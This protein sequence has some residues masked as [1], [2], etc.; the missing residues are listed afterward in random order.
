M[1]FRRRLLLLF[2]FTVLLS[3]AAVTFII[4]TLA[5]RAFDRSSDER[6]AALVAQFRREFM[7][8]GDEVAGRLRAIASTTEAGRI[9]LAAAHPSPDYSPF[10]EA[11]QSVAAAQQLDF[12][13]FVDDR[14]A[15]ISSAQWPAKFGYNELLVTSE[16]RPASFLKQE[17]LPS[18]VALGLFSVESIPAGNRK[19][20]LVGGVRLDKTFLSAIDL[21]T[22]MRVM[23][24]QISGHSADVLSPA[25][26][27][28]SGEP[29][30]VFAQITPLIGRVQE[31]SRESSDLIR[32]A[33]GGEEA[34]N[35]FPLTGPN[36]QLLAILLVGSSRQAYAD[37]RR[38]IR[39]AA[40]LATGVGL[41]L[42]IGISSWAAARVTRPVEQLARAACEIS[43]GNW[44]VQVPSAS[45]DEIGQLA[46]SFNRM[47]RELL[48]QQQRLIQSER[49]AAW[50]ELA[51]RL[52]H[53]LKNPLFPLQ[54]TVENLLR[55]RAQT[56]EQF[57]EVF[58]ES[59]SALLS[60]ISNLKT[61]IARFSDF[62]RMPQPRFQPVRL[63]AIVQ[64]VARLHL[65]QMKSASIVC[66]VD[67][68]DSETI[69]ADPD[70]LHRAISNLVLNAV[71][72]MPQG[73]TIN[74][75][76]QLSGD[77]ARIEISDTGIGL[78]PEECSRLFT[79][80]YTSKA[81]GSGLGLAIVQ[82]I[83]SD[84]HGRITVSS[85]KGTGT[86]FIIELPANRDQLSAE[87]TLARS[88]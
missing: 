59:A 71:D 65:S 17:E 69:A 81:H 58:R 46:D 79:P 33:S 5:R 34:I 86:T 75:R 77:S 28:S 42:A 51:R 18:G 20:Y 31:N 32:W 48:D 8:K 53:E 52:A 41:L 16:L 67:L 35:A 87:G 88:L 54:L 50:R 84:H 57:D 19:V 55:A 38:Q 11:A 45:R 10:L 40:L 63:R 83:V 39:F 61:V 60:E 2:A 26:L 25:N 27:I 12:L 36:H 13:E 7:R 73:G 6:A 64:E 15:I 24:Y 78:T 1:S 29:A 9:A 4:S 23:L 43:A 70:L 76:T 21:P 80:Y 49:V 82:S 72:A 66:D 74:I 44:N 47:T 3:I 56:P 68:R 22:G 14:G 37:L 85:Q 30:P 62:S